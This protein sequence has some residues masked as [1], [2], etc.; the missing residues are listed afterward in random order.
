MNSC[1]RRGFIRCQARP[2]SFRPRAGRLGLGIDQNMGGTQNHADFRARDVFEFKANTGV[3]QFHHSGLDF[4]GFARGQ[5][6]VVVAFRLTNR[7]GIIG[8]LKPFPPRKAGLGQEVLKAIVSDFKGAAKKHPP[9]R[10]SLMKTHPIF[11]A[12]GLHGPENGK[13]MHRLQAERF[14]KHS[15]FWQFGPNEF[16]E[17]Q[18]L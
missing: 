5:G 18:D 9:G 10:I 15:D 8:V 14:E 11:P 3:P 12:K 13:I 4:K 2:K 1:G 16:R 17:P 7:H 6:A